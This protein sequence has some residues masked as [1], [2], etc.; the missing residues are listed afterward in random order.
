MEFL[1]DHTMK[2]AQLKGYLLDWAVGKCEGLSIDSS[3]DWDRL[4]FFDEFNIDFEPTDNWM[5]GGKIIELNWINIT[6]EQDIWTAEIADDVPDGYISM[7]GESPLIA[8]MRCY[9]ASRLGLEVEVPDELLDYA[10]E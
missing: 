6:N 1:G 10:H 8:A 5:Q 7:R 3:W 2:T 9:V 4:C